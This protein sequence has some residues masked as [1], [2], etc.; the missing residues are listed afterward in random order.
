M[1]SEEPKSHPEPM[2][3][4]KVLPNCKDVTGSSVIA[5][6]KNKDLYL[7]LNNLNSCE[8]WLPSG[9]LNTDENGVLTESY[10]EC[11]RR[12]LAEE[13]GKE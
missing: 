7:K 8:T 9:G 2:T 1:K 11:A 5:Y 13:A 4:G 6:D 12:E 10:E 3:C